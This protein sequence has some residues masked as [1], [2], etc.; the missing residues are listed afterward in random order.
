M[1]PRAHIFSPVASRPSFRYSLHMQARPS[2]SRPRLH[3]YV[4]NFQNCTLNLT[5]RCMQRQFQF[6]PSRNRSAGPTDSTSY[7]YQF[8]S[9]SWSPAAHSSRPHFTP[10]PLRCPMRFQVFLGSMNPSFFFFFFFPFR[11]TPAASQARGQIGAAAASLCHSQGNTRT[12]L[13][14]RPTSQ[15]V[16]MPD[17]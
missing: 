11:A 1:D 7:T 15:L 6:P 14:L 9:S 13:H 4:G 16:A 5:T 8:T 12:K 17:P 2:H 10:T 3:A